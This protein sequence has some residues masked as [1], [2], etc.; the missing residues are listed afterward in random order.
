MGILGNFFKKNSPTSAPLTYDQILSR[1]DTISADEKKYYQP[2]SYYTKKTNID[3]PCER[4]V[5]TFEERIKNTNPS[6][7]GLYVPEILM[8]YFCKSFPNPKNGY[9]AYWWFKYGVRNVGAMLNSLEERGYIKI[10]EKNGKYQ[11]TDKGETEQSENEYVY[12]THLNSLDVNFD[13]WEMNELLGTG[14]KSNYV[15]VFKKNCKLNKL[16]E[17][18]ELDMEELLNNVQIAQN[19]LELHNAYTALQDYYYKK[20][21]ESNANIQACIHWCLL[22]INNLDSLDSYCAAKAESD[23]IERIQRIGLKAYNIGQEKLKQYNR[24]G[25]NMPFND[26]RKFDIRI[27]AFDKLAIIYEQQKQY[28]AAIEIT[29]LAEKYYTDHFYYNGDKWL[30]DIQKRLARLK[31]KTG[32]AK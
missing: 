26:G 29:E 15:E 30:P 4:D 18:A 27:T 7:T 21:K 3:T 11:L 5:V 32:G 20:R 24:Y 8:L 9:P 16:S 6:S 31:Q 25:A 22:D 10:D 17:N 12:F 14:D 19:Q 13:A 28:S 23:K 1:A 2:D